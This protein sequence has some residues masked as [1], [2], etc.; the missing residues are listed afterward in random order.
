MKRLKIKNEELFELSNIEK[1]EFEKYVPQLINLANQNAQGTRPKVVGQMSELFPEFLK[2]SSDTSI[3]AW[4]N[5]YSTKMP[6]AI[7]NATDKIY[8]Q[9]LNLKEALDL[10]DKNTV[11]KWVTDLIINK[12]YTGLNLQELIIKKIAQLEGKPYRLANPYEESKGIDGYIGDRAV[13]IKPS[14]YDTMQM[15]NEKIDVQIIYYEKKKDGI[16]VYT[17]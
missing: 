13:S 16:E 6:H 7:E 9:I 8:K 17:K 11:R 12:T 1:V 15:L 4:E 14:T 5:W 10:I 2:E 3:K